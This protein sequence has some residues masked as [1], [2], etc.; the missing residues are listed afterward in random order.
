MKVV[1]ID[2][3]ANLGIA[4]DVRE[5]KDGYARNHLI[6]KQLAVLATKQELAQAESRRKNEVERRS[7][8]NDEM[9]SV[10][11][12]LEERLLVP[13]RV[14]P[15]GRLYGSVTAAEIA[16]AVSERISQEVDRR[17][18]DLG[19]PIRE[20]GHHQV[21]VRLAPDIMPTLTVTVYAE[22]TEP[23]SLEEAVETAEGEEPT[24]EEV[25][26]EADAEEE[27]AAPVVTPDAP[28]ASAA[29]AE[30]E[31]ESVSEETETATEE[32]ASVADEGA[33]ADEAEASDEERDDS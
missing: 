30:V 12:L 7:R 29:E 1:L 8:L 6:P 33:D 28:E 18:V 17:A 3:V 9:S 11:G 2:E 14:G 16:E 19:Q 21:R 10:A 24:V 13:V 25:L 4:G 22:G 5:V 26:A 27:T 23:P 31:E 20:Q 15:G 32:D